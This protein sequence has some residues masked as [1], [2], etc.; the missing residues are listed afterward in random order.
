MRN[1]SATM[2]GTA[3]PSSSR[4]SAFATVPRC[5]FASD[6]AFEPIVDRTLFDAA[7]A[8]IR[9]RSHKL[10]NEEML[11]RTAAP[12]AGARLSVRPDH[13]RDRAACHPAA[14]IR[15]GSAACCAPTSWSASRPTV[16]I[17]TSRSIA[18]C[19]VCIRR[20]CPARSLRAFRRLAA[21]SSQDPATDLLTINGEFTASIVVVRCRTT[22]CRFAPLADPVRHRPVARH[23][24]RGPNGSAQPASRSTITSLPRIDMTAPRLRLAEDNGVSLD[25][26]RFETLDAFFGLAARTNL[27]EVA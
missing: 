15:A 19:A 24:G 16:T 6:G 20:C 11:T 1:T 3:A 23:H 4:R 2:S 12:A 25:A 7:Q 9:E 5:G 13:R 17:A 27:L 18:P 22:P 14:P 8:I 26:Y 10:S 21:V